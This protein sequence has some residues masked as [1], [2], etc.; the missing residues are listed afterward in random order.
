M[1]KL[2]LVVLFGG[3]VAFAQQKA[4]PKPVNVKVPPIPPSTDDLLVAELAKAA[5]TPADKM[6]L[7]AGAQMA[8]IGA[9]PTTTGTTVYL[10]TPGGY[11]MPAHWNTHG[12]HIVVVSG[13]GTI[14]I[15]G[16]ASP[17]LPG[18]YL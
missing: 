13:K 18:T 1:K 16:K 14:T 17:L 2:M 15:N 3:G 11:K 7:P 10:K 6:G 4:P 8:L 5:W 9:D 12:Q